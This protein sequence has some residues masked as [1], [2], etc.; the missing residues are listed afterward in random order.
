MG[1]LIVAV[2]LIAV[3]GARRLPAAEAASLPPCFEQL[4]EHPLPEV[5]EWAR[6]ARWAA[7]D[8]VYVSSVATGTVS[9]PGVFLYRADGTLERSWQSEE[10][11]L[12]GG[13]GLSEEQVHQ[14][15]VEVEP[16]GAWINARR[17][18]EDALAL[19]GSAR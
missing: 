19:L 8:R 16:R 12:D 14:F 11:G 17:I 3:L 2:G 15:S 1:G 7:D 10:L 13:C 9:E 5:L 4:S 6:D 18:A